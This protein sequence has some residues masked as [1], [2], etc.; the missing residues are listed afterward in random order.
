MDRGYA[1]KTKMGGW[2]E[3]GVQFLVRVRKTFK[4][5]TLKS[6][7]P[8]HPNVTRNEVVSIITREEPVRYIEFTDDEG[9]LFLFNFLTH[10]HIEKY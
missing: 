5:E 4:M 1:H 3:R 7:T 10:S 2:I 6:Y 8:T 9:T